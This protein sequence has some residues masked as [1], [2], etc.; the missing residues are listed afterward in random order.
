MSHLVDWNPEQYA[1]LEEE[2]F[3]AR[4]NLHE[5]GLFDDENLIRLFDTHPSIDFG[6]NT[7]SNS[8]SKF[9]WRE[10]DRNGVSSEVLLELLKRGHLWINLRNALTHHADVRNA[11]NSIYG[12]LESANANFKAEDRSANLLIS[13][14]DAIDY[15]HIDVPVNMLWHIRG[16]KRVWVYPPFDTRFSPQEIVEKICAAQMAE[17]APFDSGF[18]DEAEYFEAEP[19]QLITWPQLTPHRVENF[20]DEL[21][22]SLSTEHKNPRARR[23]INVHLANQFLRETFG[24]PCRSFEVDGLAAHAKQSVSRAVRRWKSLTGTEKPPKNQHEV[25][26]IVDPDSPTGVTLLQDAAVPMT[27]EERA[28]IAV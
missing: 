9:G 11:I 4:H 21:C 17:D 26:F 22:I 13:S 5:S 3:V 20:G 2:I 16:R 18:D 6:I 8:N 15:Y 7:M 19:G 12:E 27:P 23:R 14:P 10:G 28:S 24:L 25:S 1:A